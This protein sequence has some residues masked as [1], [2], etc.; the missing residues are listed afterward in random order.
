VPGKAREATIEVKI[1]KISLKKPQKKS[2]S[3][4]RASVVLT[5]IEARGVQTVNEESVLWRLY[6]TWPVESSE[7][8]CQVNRVVWLQVVH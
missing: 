3:M 2:A 6:A 1:G 5:I 4:R 7:D 8:A